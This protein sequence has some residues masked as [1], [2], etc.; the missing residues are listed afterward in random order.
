MRSLWWLPVAMTACA[1][2]TLVDT[3]Y[4]GSVET[5]KAEITAARTRGALDEAEVV[6]VAR[7]LA[8]R[9]MS[10][11]DAEAARS[12][13]QRLRGCAGALVSELEAMARGDDPRAAEAQLSLLELGR[14]NPETVVDAYAESE[15]PHFRAV[16]A[17]AAL[18]ARHGDLRQRHFQDVDARV[19]RAAFAAAQASRDRGDID[20]VLGAARR[21]PDVLARSRAIQSA[22]AIGGEGAVRGLADLWG[23]SPEAERLVIIEALAMPASRASGGRDRLIRI[24]EGEGGLLRVAAARALHR[25]PDAPE[26]LSVQVLVRAVT[27]GSTSERRLAILS[28]PRG[29][30][31]LVALRGAA[32][33]ADL[34]VQ[35]LAQARLLEFPAERDAA[36]RALRKLAKGAGGVGV[37]ARAALAADGDASVVPKLRSELE[38]PSPVARRSAALT[39]V[40]M[41]R[42]VEA[43]PVLGDPDEA[44]RLDV[45]CAMLAR[46]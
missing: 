19:R 13:V 7:A 6:E 26:S 27:S 29:E 34:E 30:E 5:L 8:V 41:G 23:P 2:S 20:A 12:N 22:G 44:L 46:D 35:I 42:V 25:P 1:S 21:E 9:A 40:R 4:H 45:A 31:A 3:A 28:V 14:L 43:A 33:D 36:R 24:I 18:G 15:S 37:Q 32:A 10:A 16:S 38:A 17:R 39:L 11:P